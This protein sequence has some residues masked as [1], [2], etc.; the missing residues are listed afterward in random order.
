MCA[1]RIMISPPRYDDVQK[2]LQRLGG[3]YAAGRQLSAQEMRRVGDPGFLSGTELLF[4]NCGGEGL[5][6]LA[7]DPKACRGLR[8]W[9]ENGGTLYASDWASEVVAAA[10]GDRV[11]FGEKDGKAAT[12]AARVSDP[13]LARRLNYSVSLTLNLDSWVRITRYPADA[14]VYLT[15]AQYSGPLA[16]GVI[17][18]KGRVVFTSFHHHA[19][20]SGSDEDKLLAWLVSLPGQHRL[21]LT[22]SNTHKRHRAP[23][24]NQVVG[25]AGAGGQRIPL[26]MG[27]GKGL[28]VFS[29][30]WE[31]G[32]SVQFGMRYLRGDEVV[33]TARPTARPPLIMTVR[34]PRSQDSVEVSRVGGTGTAAGTPQPFVFAAGLREDLLDNPDW[35]ASSVLRHLT[36]ILGSQV[37]PGMAREVLSHARML[38]ITK[39]ILSGLGYRAQVP[40]DSA[41]DED[42]A[43]V[44]ASLPDATDAPPAV[45]IGVTVADQTDA[46]RPWQLSYP[47]RGEPDPATEYLLVSVCLAAG[48]TD[49]DWSDRTDDV[50]PSGN[51]RSSSESTQ[52]Q[53][54]SS[55]TGSLGYERDIV[56]NDEFQRNY[57]FD[58][59]V[60]RAE[61]A[62]RPEGQGR[63][64]N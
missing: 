24:R 36:G 59:T 29:L 38:A 32:D 30:A 34:N 50:P 8:A 37:S 9:V 39:S 46:P 33:A 61:P 54:V 57:H 41:R 55:A 47:V 15:D 44:F 3:Q 52:W 63:R 22:S 62:T 49:F 23:I 42:Q 27:P 20:P 31:P 43:E 48:R 64:Q 6:Q 11:E 13:D 10:F 18:G 19:Q 51:V 14:Q 60:Y 26:R 4:L 53:P 28:G 1:D 5:S 56:S 40:A 58:V 17:V 45:R 12:L 2:V 21:L 25:S 16:I 35:L 7:A